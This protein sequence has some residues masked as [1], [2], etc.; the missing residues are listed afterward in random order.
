MDEGAIVRGSAS[1]PRAILSEVAILL[2]NQ[3]AMPDLNKAFLEN[4]KNVIPLRRSA[5]QNKYFLFE[6]IFMSN[7][8][9]TGRI[10]LFLIGLVVGL[11]ALGLLTILFYGSYVGLG[12]SL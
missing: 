5:T 8:G 2:Q 12:S 9:T 10:P 7:T 3:L 6:E 1:L 11:A 4:S